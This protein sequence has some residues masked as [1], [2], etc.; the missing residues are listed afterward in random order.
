MTSD[1]RPEVEIWPF[2]AC[3][4]H[5][6]TGTVRSSWTW[7]WGRHHVPQNAIS[8]LVVNL[9]F[10]DSERLHLQSWLTLQW[11][12][13][14]YIIRQICSLWRVVTLPGFSYPLLLRPAKVCWKDFMLS[15]HICVCQAPYTHRVAETPRMNRTVTI[16]LRSLCL[17][18]S[19]KYKS[20][21]KEIYITLT[22][23]SCQRI[24]YL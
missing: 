1:F 19:Q 3:A 4:M 12:G 8:S 6:A 21:D 16:F 18:Y 23:T 13:I 17:I 10:C 24:R 11:H 5:P 15:F 2:H 7:L 20:A 14:G 22:Q 9:A